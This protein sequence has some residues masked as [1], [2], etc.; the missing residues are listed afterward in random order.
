MERQIGMVFEQV[1]TESSAAKHGPADGTVEVSLGFKELQL[2]I[3]RKGKR[4]SPA[5]VSVGAT[6]SYIDAAGSLLYTKKLRTEARDDVEA[7]SEGCEIYGLDKVADRAVDTLAQGLKKQLGTSTKVRQAA[8]AKA[9]E[10]R[11]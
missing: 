5:I 7:D 9:R 3:S 4:S 2:S 8:E 1:Q 10:G 11:P 6:I